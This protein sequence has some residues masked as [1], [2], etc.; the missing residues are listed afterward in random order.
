MQNLKLQTCDG[1]IFY[2]EEEVI[3]QSNTIRTMLEGNLLFKYL[4]LKFNISLAH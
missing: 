3:K 1:E 2:V 4:L